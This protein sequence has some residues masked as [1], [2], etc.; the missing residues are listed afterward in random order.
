MTGMGCI[1]AGDGPYGGGG[2][3]GSPMTAS[4]TFTGGAGPLNVAGAS[5]KFTP[6]Q[7]VI[8]TAATGGTPPY[9]TVISINDN[10]SGKLSITNSADGTHKTVAWSG[11]AINEYQSFSLEVNISDSASH[12]ANDVYPNAGVIVLKRTS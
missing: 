6:A 3:G 9:T 7:G 10:V 11:L 4:I 12:S 8:G 5:G 2:G 1:M